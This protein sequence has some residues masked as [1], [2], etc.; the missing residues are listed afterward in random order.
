LDQSDIFWDE[1]QPRIIPVNFGSNWLSSF[2]EK[3]Y[4]RGN[5]FLLKYAL[6]PSSLAKIEK[7]M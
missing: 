4:Y 1:E 7:K 2:R 5:D 6:L 3:H